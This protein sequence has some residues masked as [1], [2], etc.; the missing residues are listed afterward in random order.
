MMSGTS[1]PS[2]AWRYLAAATSKSYVHATGRSTCVDP[3]KR[4]MVVETWVHRNGRSESPQRGVSP[5]SS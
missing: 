3:V 5:K 1:P 2:S 4:P